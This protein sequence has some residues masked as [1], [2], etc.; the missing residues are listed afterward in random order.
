M[1]TIPLCCFKECMC[2]L[3]LRIVTRSFV[4]ELWFSNFLVLGYSPQMK[5]NPEVKHVEQT[6]ATLLWFRVCVYVCVRWGNWGGWGREGGMV[7][8][9]QPPNSGSKQQSENHC[10]KGQSHISVWTKCK[11]LRQGSKK[12]YSNIQLIMKAPYF[13][14]LIYSVIIIVCPWQ[15]KKYLLYRNTFV[16]AFQN[17]DLNLSSAFSVFITLFLNLNQSFSHYSMKHWAGAFISFLIS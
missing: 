10:F 5:T 12:Y 4:L 1:W 6:K 7:A 15:R 13:S 9:G 3:V 17:Q 14:P 11:L 16:S 8:R 2:T